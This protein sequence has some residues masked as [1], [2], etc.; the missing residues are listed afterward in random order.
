MIA[1]EAAGLGPMALLARSQA[2]EMEQRVRASTREFHALRVTQRPAFAIEDSLQDRAV[3]SGLI[4]VEPL[5][6][7]IEA[8]LSDVAAYDSHAAHFGGPPPD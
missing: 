5:A 1:A 8:M 6:A 3:F 4:T 2:P 7:T